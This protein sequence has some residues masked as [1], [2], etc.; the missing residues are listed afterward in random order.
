ME[1]KGNMYLI[2]RRIAG[3]GIIASACLSSYVAYRMVGVGFVDFYEFRECIN[4]LLFSVPWACLYLYCSSKY[5]KETSL[6]SNKSHKES[7]E[8][9]L[10]SKNTK[11]I[12]E[13]I[14]VVNVLFDSMLFIFIV[15]IVRYGLSTV[16]Y[17]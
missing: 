10:M 4:L 6:L 2:L 11:T 8:K 7:K 5:R 17:C 1:T 12:Q 9:V 14:F 13:I 3:C 16:F 15:F